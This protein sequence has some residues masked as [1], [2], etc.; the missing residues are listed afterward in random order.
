MSLERWLVWKVLLGGTVMDQ[1]IQGSEVQACFLGCLIMVVHGIIFW[2]FFAV[3]LDLLVEKAPCKLFI[4][5]DNDLIK[6]SIT[7]GA[8]LSLE[9]K[10]H[11][12]RARVA[13]I[14]VTTW[15]KSE[16]LEFVETQDTALFLTEPAALIA[17]TAFFT[18]SLSF[19]TV[20]WV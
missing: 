20:H 6:V 3:S 7:H 1:T 17:Y 4:I 8:L 15:A 12:Q 13:Y 14:G 9:D 11:S 19:R 2:V 10:S 16:E 5:C 18:V